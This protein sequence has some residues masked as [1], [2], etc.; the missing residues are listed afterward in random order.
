MLEMSL[1][2]E[3]VSSPHKMWPVQRVMGKSVILTRAMSQEGLGCF[4]GFGA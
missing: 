3:T 4:Q 2:S 1:G